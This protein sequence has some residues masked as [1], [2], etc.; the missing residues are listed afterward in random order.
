[1]LLYLLKVLKQR[2]QENWVGPIKIWEG[3]G[4]Q[5]WPL[6]SLFEAYPVEEALGVVTVSSLSADEISEEESLEIKS[7]AE[8]GFGSPK[9]KATVTVSSSSS[10][11]ISACWSWSSAN[12]SWW[13]L[14]GLRLRRGRASFKG[15][16]GGDDDIDDEDWWWILKKLLLLLLIML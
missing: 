15:G 7:A 4:I 16:E 14:V 11:S 10:S 9:C 8:P 1:M 2:G 6:L 3:V 5:Y 13:S 12:S